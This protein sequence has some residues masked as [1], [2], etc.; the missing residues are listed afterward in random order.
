MAGADLDELA[1]R[2]RITGR[3][4]TKFRQSI[5]DRL[6]GLPVPSIAA[7]N[8]YCLGAG[9]ELIL[10]CDIRIA[11]DNAKFAAAEINLGIIPGNGGTQRL[12]RMIGQGRAMHMVLTGD[13]IGADQALEWGL[14]TDVVP[15]AELGKAAYVIAEKL[16]DKSPLAIQYAKDAVG[17]SLNMP[18]NVYMGRSEFFPHFRTLAGLFYFIAA[19]H[20]KPFPDC[21]LLPILF[22]ICYAHVRR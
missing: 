20:R 10:A 22:T 17:H 14:V 12:P 11:S 13:R 2:D 15:Q 16:A 18:G 1:A 5:Y 19:F 4:Q 8:G 21:F 9:L 7:V 6:S 3:E